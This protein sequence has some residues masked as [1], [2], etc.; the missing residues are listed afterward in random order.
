MALVPNVGQ[1]KSRGNIQ[2]MLKALLNAG[3]IIFPF[4]GAPTNGIVGTGTFAG[5]AGI[6]SPLFDYT[7]GVL[8][9]NTGTKASPVWTVQSLQSITGDVT[10]A[11][12]VS[13]IGAGKVLSAM[14]DAQLVKIAT[15]TIASADITGT[16]AGQLGHANGVVLV[17]SGGAH[18]VTEFISAIII[19]DFGVAAYTGGGN[20]GIKISGGGIALSGVLANTVIIQASADGIWYFNPLAATGI[21]LSENTGLNFVTASAPTQPGTAAGVIRWKIAYRQYATGL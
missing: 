13:A 11:S 2:A 9:I 15:G 18:V 10:I 17:A 6:G 14:M 7:N 4:A 3:V 12:G 1:F 20:T 5:I 21:V 8:Y 16:G 19:M